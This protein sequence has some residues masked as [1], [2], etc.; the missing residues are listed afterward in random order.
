MSKPITRV[1]QSNQINTWL[2]FIVVSEFEDKLEE[3][4][5]IALAKLKNDAFVGLKISGFHDGQF[6][7]YMAVIIY[8]A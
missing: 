3:K 7:S 4:I 8:K 5:N 2:L 6:N 1:Q